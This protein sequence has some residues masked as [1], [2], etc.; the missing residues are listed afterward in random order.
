VSDVQVSFAREVVSF[1]L[2]TYAADHRPAHELTCLHFC[3]M[4][5]SV[6]SAYNTDA[7]NMIFL[8]VSEH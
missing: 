6:S 8:L 7:A 3:Q 1:A 5:P 4:A 2:A